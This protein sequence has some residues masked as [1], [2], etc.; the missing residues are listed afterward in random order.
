MIAYDTSYVSIH[1]AMNKAIA[2]PTLMQVI[3]TNW[4]EHFVAK[5]SITKL[6]LF[7]IQIHSSFK[8]YA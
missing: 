3:I 4:S 8:K 6:N 7:K 5:I 1:Y 2:F